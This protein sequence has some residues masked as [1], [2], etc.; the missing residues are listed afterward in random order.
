MQFLLI[1]LSAP[2]AANGETVAGRHRSS[3]SRPG[4]SAVLGLAAAA[5]GLEREDEGHAVLANGFGYAVRVDAG[6]RSLLD[7]HTAEV[8]RGKAGRDRRTRAA[9]LAYGDLKCIPTNRE[10]RTD[11]LYT[12]AL[13]ARAG[14]RWSLDDLAR[15]LRSPHYVLYVGRKA[16]PLSLPLNPEI[17]EA[18]TLIE[19]LKRRPAVPSA[20]AELMPHVLDERP[21]I[22]CDEGAPGVVASLITSRRDALG[23][24]RRTFLER[25]EHIMRITP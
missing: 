1:T 20:I 5:L 25:T 17:V 15:A 8:P 16:C 4:R 11:T 23:P 13:W 10:Y 24:G 2:I 9:E 3:W 12:I 19:A 21:E 18:A 7:Y 6:G 22:A 14:A